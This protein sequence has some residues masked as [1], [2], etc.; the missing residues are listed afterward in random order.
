MPALSR[1]APP[2]EGGLAPPLVRPPDVE[3]APSLQTLREDLPAVS[4]QSACP[5][6]DAVAA[7][8]CASPEA[9]EERYDAADRQLSQIEAGIRAEDD[10]AGRTH[11]KTVTVAAQVAGPRASAQAAWLTAMSAIGTDQ[12][13]TAIAAFEVAVACLYQAYLASDLE[14]TDDPFTG[15]WQADDHRAVLAHDAGVEAL[16]AGWQ[17]ANGFVK[18]A[19]PSDHP[20]QIRVGDPGRYSHAEIAG[21][22]AISAGLL[23]FL[24]R[25]PLAVGELENTSGGF[26]PGPLRNATAMSLLESEGFEV[27]REHPNPDGSYDHSDIDS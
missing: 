16:V 18:F 5:T 10:P 24:P 2:A 20:D 4:A 14:S 7:D 25:S 21:G 26:R 3:A 15:I 22:T 17:G 23:V 1:S 6:L 8:Q 27:I 11:P 13:E 9:L 12:E 19:I